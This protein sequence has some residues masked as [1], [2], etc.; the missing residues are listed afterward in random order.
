[1][2][3]DEETSDLTTFGTPIGRYKWKRMTFAISPAPEVFQRRLTQALEELKDI[4]VIADDILVTDGGSTLEE[5][6]T[7]HDRNL[8]ALQKRCRDK[9]IKLSKEKF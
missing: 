5:A 1:M 6:R 8:L 4:Y 2:V 9:G 3:L 7:N